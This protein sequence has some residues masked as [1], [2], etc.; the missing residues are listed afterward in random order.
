[1]VMKTLWGPL[2][3]VFLLPALY[4]V[5]RPTE[6]METAPPPV[7]DSIPHQTRS[8]AETV[9]V[10]P[11]YVDG[12]GWTV[13]L[14][15]SNVVADTP[16]EVAVDVYDQAGRLI[17]DLFDS[18]STFE[19]PPQGSR[20][21]RSV[22]S[23][24]IRRGW[25]QV[26]SDTGAVSGLLTYRQGATGIEVGVAP[27]ELGD[28]FALFV[29][30]SGDVGAGVAIFKP[31]AS[32][33]LELRIR[34]EEGNDPLEGMFLSWGDFQRSARTLPEWLGVEG[35]DAG[36]P[37]DIRGLLFLRTENDSPFAP[38]G[39]RS[40]K[41]SHSL[42]SVPAI[43]VQTREPSETTLIFPDYVDGGGWTVQLALSNVGADTAA[44]VV[45]DAYDQDGWP[46]LDLFDS[47]STFEIP[48]LGSRVLRSTGT[49]A[50]R[51]GWI[52]VETDGASVGG[53]LT[54]RQ[55]ETGIEVSVEPVELGTQF[56]LFAE[57]SSVIGTG[58]AIFK[59]E[60]SSRIELRIRDED[61][62][63]PLDEMF[64]PW[65]GFHQAAR[66]LPEWFDVEGVETGFLRD[67]RGLLFLR[68][69][70]E[71]GFAPLGLRFGKGTS[72]LSAVPAI[73]IPDGGG[74]DGGQ[75][76]PPTVTLSAS[77][78][79]IDRGQ[80][81]TLMWSSTNAES[82]EIAPGIGVVP[83]SG[84][85]KVSPNVTTTYRI[86]VTGAD[87]QTATAS[88]TVSVVISERVALGAVFDALGGSGW[89]HSD[90]WLTDAPLGDWY[91][92]DVD[93]Q[94]RVIG[95][96]LVEWVDTEEGYQRKIGIG[97]TGEI[98]PELGSLTHLRNLDLS[99]NQLT[100]PIPVELGQLSN[101]TILRLSSNQLTGP[102]PPELGRLFNLN[103][104][105]LRWNQLVGE[106]PPELGELSN[107]RNLFLGRNRLSGP[108]P[109]ELGNLS[110]LTYLELH[111]NE[112]AGP[113]RPELGQLSNLT[114]LSLY[115]N[116]LT[117]PIR[118]ELG[119][120]SNLTFLSLYNNQLTGP[121]PPELGNL[122]NL[123]YLELHGNE[124]AGP[125]PPSFLQIE[126]LDGFTFSFNAGLCAP[127]T[128]DFVAWLKE[129]KRHEG[130]YCNEADVAVLDAF[131]RNT[132]GED[133]MNSSNWLGDVAISN[134][135]GVRADSLGRVTGLDL[136]DNGLTGRFPNILGQLAQM[137]ELR[138]DGNSLTGR[139]PLSL[140]RIPLQVLH[141]ADTELC[142]PAEESF[143]VWLRTISLHE[144]T[145]R[146][147]APLTDRDIL[148]ALYHA[149]GGA[150]WIQSDKW[151][152]D[153][154]LSDWF[155][156][157][158]DGRGRVT[159]LELGLNQLEGEIPS[160]LG[161]LSHL[162]QLSLSANEL[163]GPIPAE[164]GRLEHLET[165]FLTRNN[166]TGA[167]PAELGDL[168]SLTFLALGANALEGPIPPE[169]GRLTSIER[170]LLWGNNLTGPIPSQLGN[171]SKAWILSVSANN[172]SGRI[173]PQLGNLANMKRLEL[174][175]NAFNGVIPPELGGL[176]N[177][178]I[179][180]L[181]FNELTGPVPP[182]KPW[183]ASPARQLERSVSGRE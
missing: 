98:P 104:L 108:I 25:I 136:N 50:I 53:L 43:Q 87:G 33:G 1:M 128:T 75:A 169:L 41:R 161:Y 52:E 115:N 117:G 14:A 147:C 106:I 159:H 125:I 140:T 36:F 149:T 11:D 63:D 129:I 120:L 145:G 23:G 8:P 29:E 157:Q 15:L 183:A 18:G 171:L 134:W 138:I 103:S 89:T 65:R 131:F 182:E 102:I 139:L 164:L 16:A 60:A 31:D 119:Q 61:G 24:T 44:E 59:P 12:G 152:T 175:G 74:I 57:E 105:Y 112:L 156:V 7:D 69:E 88:V 126:Q 34:D 91:G 178:E 93:S 40:G 96:R 85:R 154:S 78:S 153:A 116:Q 123:T 135:Y 176:A 99:N 165:L 67:F 19:I 92:V 51:R 54:Y 62:N 81:T 13:Q 144:G 110:N 155:G 45:V 114:F 166:L 173:P 113:I 174:S 30:E 80:V 124:L 172:L 2:L 90:N 48:P 9:L 66:T 132:G 83:T 46:I 56:A 76:P 148:V 82:A 38:L 167:I 160:E 118:P 79:S 101:L 72:S 3:G 100:G 170:F 68:T 163:T 151:L 26:R 177:L 127:G 181:G 84:S 150:N 32:P 130:P 158:V 146:N 27:V 6:P 37:G 97:L 142:A 35:A 95:L 86:M 71:S 20:V 141:Y 49:G 58:L 39:L 4:S 94:G 180:W 179:L 42:S 73:R 21:L 22:G 10:F 162:L 70:D 64:L 17:L 133:W 28:R 111:G 107:L 168:S 109:A 47:G 77:P 55:T 143:Q 122:S 5:Q 137:T 121:I